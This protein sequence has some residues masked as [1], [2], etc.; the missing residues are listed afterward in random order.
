MGTLLPRNEATVLLNYKLC[1]TP[2]HTALLVEGAAG[3][4]TVLVVGQLLHSWGGSNMCGTQVTCFG[5]SRHTLPN[6]TM[7]RLGSQSWPEEGMVS[8]D[9]HSLGMRG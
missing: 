8:R 9:S 6:V 5:V 7:K 2:E 3:G 4:V 1:L